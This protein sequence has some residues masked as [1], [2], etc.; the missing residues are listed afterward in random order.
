MTHLP[1]YERGHNGYGET[2]HGDRNCGTCKH[3]GMWKVT[4]RH[5][6]PASRHAGCPHA[7]CRSLFSPEGT[8]S[9]KKG[10]IM[11]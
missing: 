11:G 7:N 10:E 8:K 9:K 3:S 6:D 2:V 4:K 1:R 5:M